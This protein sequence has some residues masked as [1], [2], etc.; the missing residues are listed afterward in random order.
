MKHLF[1]AKIFVIILA[2]IIILNSKYVVAGQIH[3]NDILDKGSTKPLIVKVAS[4]GCVNNTKNQNIS[5]INPEKMSFNTTSITKEESSFDILLIDN[6]E[7][8]AYDTLTGKKTVIDEV[9]YDIRTGAINAYLPIVI[10]A[11]DSSV[12]LYNPFTKEKEEF[13]KSTEITLE[14]CT[15]SKDGK[16]AALSI[17]YPK[18]S[19]WVSYVYDLENDIVTAISEGKSAGMT[20]EGD[21]LIIIKENQFNDKNQLQI[22]KYTVDNGVKTVYK[23]NVDDSDIRVLNDYALGGKAFAVIDGAK[24]DKPSS[25]L[26]Y[27]FSDNY[28]SRF[29]SYNK[30]YEDYMDSVNV[31]KH[32]KSLYSQLGRWKFPVIKVKDDNKSVYISDGTFIFYYPQALVYGE[33]EIGNYEG[34]KVINWQDSFTK[35]SIKDFFNRSDE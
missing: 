29:N 14:Y 24:Y 23:Y 18:D 13:F 3:R 34:V 19:K 15:W 4:S 26:A 20:W 8:I 32:I 31:D 28:V 16:Y 7:I 25:G 21:T 1:K 9:E 22:L 17:G 35:N 30:F 33:T 5:K 10:V 27:K 12:Y 2:T 6:N 11:D